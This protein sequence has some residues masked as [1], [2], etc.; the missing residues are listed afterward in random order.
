M[1]AVNVFSVTDKVVG[2]SDQ[3][4]PADAALQNLLIIAHKGQQTVFDL[5]QAVHHVA[6][7]FALIEQN[8]AG[9]KRY[10]LASLGSDISPAAK[11]YFLVSLGNDIPV[12]RPGAI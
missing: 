9:T 10:S 6:A 5:I 7:V 8:I 2:V 1:A 11:R 12:L 3:L 4:I